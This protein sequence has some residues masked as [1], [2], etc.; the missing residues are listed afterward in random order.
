MRKIDFIQTFAE[1]L[2][3]T[4]V[5]D[6]GVRTTFLLVDVRGAVVMPQGV[7][8]GYYLMLGVRPALNNY[9]KRPLIFIHEREEKT[10]SGLYESLTDD[11]RRFRCRVIYAKQERSVREVDGFYRDLHKRLTDS[12]MQGISL[13]PAPSHADVDYGAVLIQEAQRDKALE[14]PQ[15]EQTTL[16]E[17]LW[18]LHAD[19]DLTDKQHYA[20]HALRYLLAGFEKHS[21]D[22]VPSL[23]HRDHKARARR[24]WKNIAA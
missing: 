16:K 13:M 3:A 1:G 11:I 2:L 4:G 5:A 12:R 18:S 22:V 21:S 9:G 23:L 10:L 14:L 8:P 7:F 15:Y 6:T 20:F 19:T 17:Q 24:A